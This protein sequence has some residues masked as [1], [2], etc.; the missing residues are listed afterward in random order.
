LKVF[1]ESAVLRSVE[2]NSNG[3]DNGKAF[4]FLS[5]RGTLKNHLTFK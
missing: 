1:H 5:G 4:R 3:H 2:K